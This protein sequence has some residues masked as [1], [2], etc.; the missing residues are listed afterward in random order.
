MKQVKGDEMEIVVGKLVFLISSLWAFIVL[1][2]IVAG[3]LNQRNRDYPT[4]P[5]IRRT[6]SEKPKR[7]TIP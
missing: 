6:S 2:R 3:L 1:Y 5:R 7:T 4:P